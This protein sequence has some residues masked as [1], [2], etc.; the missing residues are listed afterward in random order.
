MENSVFLSFDGSKVV[1]HIKI[2][3]NDLK[4]KIHLIPVC[5]IGTYDYFQNIVTYVGEDIPCI[6]ENVKLGS[7]S[8]KPHKPI[9]NLDDL[10]EIFSITYD[11]F[12]QEYKSLIKRSYRKFSG[13]EVKKLHKLVRREVYKSNK[14]IMQIYELC[15]KTNFGITNV[16]LIQVYWC[17]ILELEHQ[18]IAIDYENDIPNRSNW[19]HGDVNFEALKNK[20]DLS[21]VIKQ[22]LTNPTQKQISEIQKE[23]YLVMQSILESINLYRIGDSSQRRKELAT[24]LT[25]A[26]TTQYQA[27]ENQSPEFLMKM[28]NTIVESGI[29]ILLQDFNEI[30]IFYGAMHMIPIEKFL[31][32]AGFKLR[33]EERFEVF[34]VNIL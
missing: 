7:E 16:I 28:R 27:L 20:A 32:D 12:W 9:K 22:V 17:E 23:R 13:R 6:F 24:M 8:D 10:I 1:S 14:K 19:C 30:M 2:Y 26:M 15:E 31:L 18:T 25:D 33:S 3:E 21:E 34:D 4:Q 5:H 11:K 29:S